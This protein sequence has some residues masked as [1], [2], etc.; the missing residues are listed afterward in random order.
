MKVLKILTMLCLTG[1]ISHTALAQP[2]SLGPAKAIGVD[3]ANTPLNRPSPDQKSYTY[4]KPEI[5]DGFF[6]LAFGTA[7]S[8]R[9]DDSH[10]IFQ[11]LLLYC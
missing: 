2:P 11:H 3:L 4:W 10:Q 1:L 6:P 7:D 8:W 9:S 5:V